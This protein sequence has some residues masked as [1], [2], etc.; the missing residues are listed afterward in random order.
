[1]KKKKKL[2]KTRK[3]SQ[4]I[5]LAEENQTSVAK[6]NQTSIAAKNK[7]RNPLL[8]TKPLLPVQMTN[9]SILTTTHTVSKEKENT[10]KIQIHPFAV[11]SLGLR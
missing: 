4:T 3:E 6:E 1:M 7:I 8:K 5:T 2:A 10:E 9:G 11:C